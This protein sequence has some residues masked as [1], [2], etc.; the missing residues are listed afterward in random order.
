MNEVKEVEDVEAKPAKRSKGW[1]DLIRRLSAQRNGE[2]LQVLNVLKHLKGDHRISRSLSML[3]HF[4][5]FCFGQASWKT[6]QISWRRLGNDWV[7]WNR[8]KRRKFAGRPR[9]NR[10]KQQLGRSVF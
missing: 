2:Y 10:K 8:R 4:D 3:N 7:L 1:D 6:K 5:A 9:I